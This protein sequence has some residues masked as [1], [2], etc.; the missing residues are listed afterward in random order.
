MTDDKTKFSS[1]TGRGG[2]FLRGIKITSQRSMKIPTNS[3]LPILA[4]GSL[5][6]TSQVLARQG[7][8]YQCTQD[9]SANIDGGQVILLPKRDFKFTWASK[10]KITFGGSEAWFGDST[11][12]LTSP[13]Y[14]ASEYFE[15][16]SD[17]AITIYNRGR[18]RYSLTYQAFK[19]DFTVITANCIKLN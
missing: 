13:Y 4:V 19:K 8:T 11:C 6:T 10:Q 15:C 5:L 3:I 16:V 7:D 1:T 18:F 9:F 14:P 12:E 17:K 2:C